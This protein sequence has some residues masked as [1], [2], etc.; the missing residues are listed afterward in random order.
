M[1]I[2]RVYTF[3][4]LC[5]GYTLTEIIS[6]M[7]IVF[8]LKVNTCTCGRN[9]LT[10]AVNKFFKILNKVTSDLS[11]TITMEPPHVHH[12]CKEWHTLSSKCLIRH[13][14]NALMSLSSSCSPALS[15]YFTYTCII[16]Y[17]NFYRHVVYMY[18]CTCAYMRACKQVMCIYTTWLCEVSLVQNSQN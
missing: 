15:K 2:V 12:I 6:L 18:T 1:Y 3:Y 16:L 4:I 10:C 8:R 17:M 9:T 5:L 11:L 14:L 13:N 7:Y